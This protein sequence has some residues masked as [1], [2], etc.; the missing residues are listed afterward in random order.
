MTRT[1]PHAGGAL[2]L[3]LVMTLGIVMSPSR[4]VAA[5]DAIHAWTDES[6]RVHYSNQIEPRSGVRTLAAPPLPTAEEAAADRRRAERAHQELTR[7]Q[8]TRP[9]EAPAEEDTQ[10]S[11]ERAQRIIVFLREYP[12]L[13]LLRPLDDGQMTV[14]HADERAPLLTRARV[15]IQQRCLTAATV[16]MHDLWSGLF[17]PRTARTAVVTPTQ[18]LPVPVVPDAPARHRVARPASTRGT[19]PA[20]PASLGLSFR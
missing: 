20:A 8:S 12:E 19:P 18:F 11:C 9:T 2:T 13:P 15:D 16:D 1:I 3:A 17:W 7:V 14:L 5:G 6:G 4:A 10:V